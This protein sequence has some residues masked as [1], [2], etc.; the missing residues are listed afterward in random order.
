MHLQNCQNQ[1]LPTHSFREAKDHTKAGANLDQ[2][3]TARGGT[4]SKS[5]GAMQKAHILLLKTK[6][7]D[8]FDKAFAETMVSDHK[9]AVALF[10][11]A[12]TDLDDADLKEFA[13]K[14]LPTL[15]HHLMASE[16][17]ASE[18]GK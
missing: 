11:K 3:V 5:P 8:S 17:L 13:K 9:E 10:E 16:R 15:K 2:I 7:G 1:N 18:T 6:S 4:T 14:T 12:S